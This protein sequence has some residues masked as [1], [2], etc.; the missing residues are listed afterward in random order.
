M[1]IGEKKTCVSTDNGIENIIIHHS[2]T[3]YNFLFEVN[4]RFL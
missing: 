3:L 1:Y 4:A 2:S